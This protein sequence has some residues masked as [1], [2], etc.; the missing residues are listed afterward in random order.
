MGVEYSKLSI[1]CHTS[2]G[3]GHRYHRDYPS[4]SSDSFEVSCIGF[5]RGAE[6]RL[7]A[8]CKYSCAD[9][10]RVADSSPSPVC[11]DCFSLLDAVQSHRSLN[12]I[13]QTSLCRSVWSGDACTRTIALYSSRCRYACANLNS[14]RQTCQQDRNA[15]L[16]AAIAVSSSIK[17]V[18]STI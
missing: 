16:C 5:E 2:E 11:F 9:F 14:K 4:P 3:C 6:D 18:T 7:L 17:R 10:N 13:D 15:T 12:T 8:K 1:G